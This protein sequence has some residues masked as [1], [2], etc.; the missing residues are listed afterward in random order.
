[1]DEKGVTFIEE[2]L[3]PKAK[4]ELLPKGSVAGREEKGVRGT[5]F[6]LLKL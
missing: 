6:F 4:E 3:L 5:L 1:M 2:G